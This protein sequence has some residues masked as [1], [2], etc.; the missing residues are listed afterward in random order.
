M[1][2]IE[3]IEYNYLHSRF[4]WKKKKNKKTSNIYGFLFK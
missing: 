4:K 1:N 2:S 3:I